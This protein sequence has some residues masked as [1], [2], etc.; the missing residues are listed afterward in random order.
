MSTN[1]AS[2]P[3]N[4]PTTAAVLNQREVELKK[5]DRSS[6]PSLLSAANSI[7]N[8]VGAAARLDPNE[9]NKSF[10]KMKL[11]DIRD[12]LKGDHSGEELFH[13]VLFHALRESVEAY[14]INKGE[15]D[16][17]KYIV[18]GSNRKNLSRGDY[19][20]GFVSKGFAARDLIPESKWK[21]A[22]TS[23]DS[24]MKSHALPD[25]AACLF[26]RGH[27]TWE[28]K[29]YFGVVELEISD[30][31]CGAFS[32][33][34]DGK[35]LNQIDL[36]AK[37]GALAQAIMYNL[38]TVLLYLARRGKLTSNLPLAVIAAQKYGKKV[39]TDLLQWVWGEL[40]IARASGDHIR[41]SVNDFGGFKEGDNSVTKALAL[42]LHV[43]S[44]GLEI[45]VQVRNELETN[46]LPS[47]LPASGLTLRV[48]D[49]E[50][51]PLFCASPIHGANSFQTS[52]VPSKQLNI[53]QGDM[54]KGKVKNLR[55]IL[56]M[57][58]NKP[59][60]LSS[61]AVIES[62]LE[63]L[64][65]VSSVAVHRYL[66]HPSFVVAAF[67]KMKLVFLE[68]DAFT[69]EKLQ[70]LLDEFGTVL[71]A[72]VRTDTGLIMIMK[73]LSNF[74]YEDLRP[75]DKS[76]YIVH[77]WEGFRRL[78][79]QV[80][81]PLAQFATVIHPD[82]RPG[83]DITSNILLHFNEA[84]NFATM[85]LI[86]YESLVKFDD[87]KAPKRTF[88]KYL[89]KDETGDAM[90]FLWWQC[91]TVGYAWI[92]KQTID[93]LYT[94]QGLSGSQMDKVRTELSSNGNIPDWMRAFSDDA[95]GQVDSNKLTRL[96]DSL[97][98]QFK[99]QNEAFHYA[100]EDTDDRRRGRNPRSKDHSRKEERRNNE[101]SGDR[102]DY[103]RRDWNVGDE[104][105]K[106]RKLNPHD[107]EYDDREH[108]IKIRGREARQ[109]IT[110]E[111]KRKLSQERK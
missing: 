18:L 77:L 103:M 6:P 96:L 93:M 68:A 19:A 74:N 89:S 90:T 53:S 38:G 16:A 63:V 5:V 33:D 95:Q 15:V 55:E 84:T 17:D 36:E 107:R 27:Q 70:R 43:L 4:H 1:D 3:S 37:H 97:S 34:P 91:L 35:V 20:V 50:L 45:A 87:W 88:G 111:I 46:T 82:F 10:S 75:M 41:Y 64:V 94:K 52:T 49:I 66:V 106:R 100:Y 48:K 99:I 30:Q 78:V 44:F 26:R 79:E 9:K 83:Y 2:L 21:D 98:E 61:A 62:Q 86:D 40:H 59:F 31:A 42:Y 108:Q 39:E 8:A 110:Y 105:T 80:L 81:L 25:H 67:E 47:P 71:Y 29:D 60:F 72:A 24:G 92:E 22:A 69:K 51:G 101:N 65:K 54:F 109:Q 14:I 7:R 73:D 56:A 102:T 58:K 13:Y 104:S 57:S 12:I 11:E 23:T 76:E 32:T 85:K 28:P